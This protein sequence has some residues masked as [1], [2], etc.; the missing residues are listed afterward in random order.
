MLQEPAPSGHYPQI[1]IGALMDQLELVI[2]AAE[3]GDWSIYINVLRE[4][5]ATATGAADSYYQKGVE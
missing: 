5:S 2:A 3:R 4:L 1:W